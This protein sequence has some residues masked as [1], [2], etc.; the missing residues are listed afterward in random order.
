MGARRAARD[1]AT[2]DGGGDGPDLGG[3][4]A[5]EHGADDQAQQREG[6]GHGMAL[7]SLRARWTIIY[8]GPTC[9]SYQTVNS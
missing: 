1:L 5:R 3:A 4:G 9:Q 7:S 2:S 8:V 6:R